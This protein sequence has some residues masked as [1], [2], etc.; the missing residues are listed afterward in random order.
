MRIPAV[1]V[2]SVIVVAFAWSYG[3]AWAVFGALAVAAFAFVG[4]RQAMRSRLAGTNTSAPAGDM[5]AIDPLTMA[6]LM[7]PPSDGGASSHCGDGGSSA[8]GSGGDCG[9]GSA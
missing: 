7:T 4:I 1:L 8:A 2:V 5:A 9:G 6:I 3:P